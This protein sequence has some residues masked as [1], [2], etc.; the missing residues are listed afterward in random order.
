MATIEVGDRVKVNTEYDDAQLVGRLG[1][2]VAVDAPPMSW[3]IRVRLDV[4]IP[5][6]GY[7]AFFDEFELD[8][9]EQHDAHLLVQETP[10]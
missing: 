7:L 8:V 9:V 3:P 6:L 4:P 1:K 10:C 2:V 5:A